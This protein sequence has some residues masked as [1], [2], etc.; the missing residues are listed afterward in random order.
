[1]KERPATV[2]QGIKVNPPKICR[3]ITKV[4]I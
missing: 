3:T 1:M 4:R 2:N